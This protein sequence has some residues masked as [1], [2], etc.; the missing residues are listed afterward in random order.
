MVTWALSLS[1]ACCLAVPWVVDTYGLG[2]LWFV[3]ALMGAVQ[4]PLFPSSTL[5]LSRWMPGASKSGP[6]EKAWGTSMLDI[7][8]SVGSLLI[9]PVANTLAEAIGWRRTYHTIGAGSLAFVG[10]WQLF[11]ADSPSLCWFISQKE[12]LYITEHLPPPKPKRA[13]SS[14]GLLGLP[15]AMALHPGLWA[16]FIA[17]AAFNFGSPSPPSLDIALALWC[18]P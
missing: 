16:V 11:A 18:G 15:V 17:H 13:T 1:A 12:L 5:F 7:G 10:L 3:I 4:G 6:D 2:G 14:G 8:I 9:I